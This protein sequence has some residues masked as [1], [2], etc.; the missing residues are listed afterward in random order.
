MRSERPLQAPCSR[1]GRRVAQVTVPHVP[2]SEMVHA[3]P[4]PLSEPTS[5]DRCA[6][7]GLQGPHAHTHG[8]SGRVSLWGMAPR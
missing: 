7:S 2:A 6:L 8:S 3:C 4:G 5:R 1:R